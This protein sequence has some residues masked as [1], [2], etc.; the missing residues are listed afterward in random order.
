VQITNKV[1]LILSHGEAQKMFARLAAQGLF[2]TVEEVQMVMDTIDPPA[3]C[4]TCDVSES[5]HGWLTE[6]DNVGATYCGEE[7]YLVGKK[8]KKGGG[9]KWVQ[10]AHMHEGTFI[11]KAKEHHMTP[12]QFQK[13]VL[14][15]KGNYDTTTVRQANLRK[16][17]VGF[18]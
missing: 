14:S 11:R 7:C 1:V 12:A 10:G 8:A 18:E 4:R 13:H 3:A 17:L 9:R 5:P 6:P 16:T 2:P 15:N